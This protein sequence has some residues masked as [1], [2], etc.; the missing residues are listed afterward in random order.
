[1]KKA[2]AYLLAA[3]LLLACVPAMALETKYQSPVLGSEVMMPDTLEVLAEFRS[4]DGMSD[5]I[6]FTIPGTDKQVISTLTYVPEFEGM[7]T[8]DVPKEEVE[9]W[10]DF[11]TENYPKH[12]KSVMLRPN[13]NSSQRIYRYYGLN[14]E[15]KWI[16]SYTGVLD[17]LYVS[18]CCEADKF[19]Y[20]RNEMQAIFEAFNVSFQLF[21]RSRGVD[22]V[23]YSADD[24]EV[25]I[26]NL[27]YDA[28][29][30]SIFNSY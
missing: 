26:F 6:Y 23:R 18:T 14:A 2:M 7:Q 17:G 15:G 21:A 11:F 30:D 4:T 16:L 3:A 19:G 28:S 12:S 13:Y 8:K 29:P 20:Q 1:M 25:E 10:K 22:F 27:L 24:F 9:A 5:Y